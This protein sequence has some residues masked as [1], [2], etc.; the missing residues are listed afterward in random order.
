MV[1]KW[2][3]YCKNSLFNEFSIILFIFAYQ[4]TNS[5]RLILKTFQ[6]YNIIY[7]PYTTV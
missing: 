6:V 3:V 7:V 2:A 4:Q 5:I 1:E